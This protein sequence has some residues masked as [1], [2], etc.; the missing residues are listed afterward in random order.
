MKS[1]IQQKEIPGIFLP[2]HYLDASKHLPFLAYKYKTSVICYKVPRKPKQ[3]CTTTY[4]W[5]HLELKKVN[6]HYILW[7]A[8]PPP[9][10]PCI[11]LC[12]KHFQYIIT[13]KTKNQVL[14]KLLDRRGDPLPLN[15]NTK[16]GKLIIA[17]RLTCLKRKKVKRGNIHQI[18]YL[19]T[20]SFQRMTL[21]WFLFKPT[22]LQQ[23]V[24]KR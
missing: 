10:V 22:P 11:V 20:K 3:P 7:C 9:A 12:K 18:Y 16:G 4:L 8:P 1:L 15:Q 13:T 2:L 14:K 6:N 17:E 21:S 23:T 19:K 5:C 24:R